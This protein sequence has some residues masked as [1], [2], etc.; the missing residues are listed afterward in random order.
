MQNDENS[1]DPELSAAVANGN[2][3]EDIQIVKSSE[4]GRNPHQA[5]GK[6]RQADG[7]FAEANQVAEKYGMR[8]YKSGYE[9]LMPNEGVLSHSSS[10][11]RR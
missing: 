6:Q 9:M 2:R 7:E 11:L 3:Q 10:Q 4:E 5:S 1:I 8:N